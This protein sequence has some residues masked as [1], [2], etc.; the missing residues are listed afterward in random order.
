MALSGN[1]LAVAGRL[2]NAAGLVVT[3]ARYYATG[4]PP[5]PPPPPAVSTLGVDGIT[6]SGARVTGTVNAN[7][8][9]ATW[10][11]EYG[12]TTAYGTKSAVQNLAATTN[13][14]DVGVNVT[15][16]AAGTRYHARL[17]IANAIGTTPGDNVTFVTLGAAGGGTVPA[18]PVKGAKKICKVPKVVGKK[19]NVA[20]KKVSAAG[21]KFKVVYKKSKRPKNIV[22][23]QS[24]KANKKLVYRAVV[25]LTVSTK[26]TPKKKAEGQGQGQVELE[27]DHQ[28]LRRDEIVLSRGRSAQPLGGFPT[29]PSTTRR[30]RSEI[31]NSGKWVIRARGKPL[32]EGVRTCGGSSSCWLRSVRSPRP[33]LLRKARIPRR[34]RCRTR[35]RPRG[36]RSRTGTRSTSAPS[37]PA[38]STPA[39][40]ARAPARSSFPGAA[41][42]TRGAT[43]IEYDHGKLWVAGAAGGTARVYHVKTGA[44][45]REYQLTPTPTT[46][47]N[48]VVVTKKAAYFT[49]SQQ[50][51]ISRIAIGKN[52]APGDA[53]DDPADR[54]L[55]APRRAVQPQRHRRHPERQVR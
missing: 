52:G 27:V 20:R 51:A 40:C 34:S 12:T 36:S 45:I 42:G 32:P 6:S 38:R 29:T 37:R 26:F 24:R 2:T 49:D 1:M 16:L 11:L 44:L 3:A 35:S 13:D 25:K 5:P 48:D 47:I 28:G 8:T 15:G 39:A 14:V 22:L 21:C 30:T 9:A 7:G 23:K 10:W 43:G 46:F 54:R 17:V 19:L 41:P 18:G 33:Q 4:A 50:P 53:D 55:P 31:R